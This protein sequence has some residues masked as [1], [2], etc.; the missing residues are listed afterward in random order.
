M[1]RLPRCFRV[2]DNIIKEN[3]TEAAIKNGLDKLCSLL[4]SSISG[5]CESLVTLYGDAIIKLLV[6]EIDPSAICKELKLCSP[7]HK[8]VKSPVKG[9]VTCEFC[10]YA[11]TYLDNQLKSDRTEEKIKSALDSLC[12]HLPSSVSRQCESLINTNLDFLVQLLV[13]EL[14]PTTICDALKV[15]TSSHPKVKTNPVECEVCQEAIGY[16]DSVLTEKSTE[17]EIK[18]EV[19][20][21]CS[22]LPAAID[23]ECDALITEYGDELIKLVVQQIQPDTICKALKVC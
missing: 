15:C 19:K 3:K 9:E 20:S 4:P 13:R 11:M 14:D 22:H 2:L 12:A 7:A 23:N 17:D 16:L 21:L 6:D 18:T 5:Q 10:K 8:V 1:H